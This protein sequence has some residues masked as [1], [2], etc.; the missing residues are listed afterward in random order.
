MQTSLNP[1]ARFAAFL[2]ALVALVALATQLVL[3]TEH[4]GGILPAL[5]ILVRYFTIL[6]NL[7]VAVTFSAMALSG[8]APGAGWLTGL[9]LWILIVGIVYHALL[10]RLFHP[11]GID[12]WTDQGLHTA[13]PLLAALWWLIFAPKH[14]LGLKHAVWWLGWP[15]AYV[16]YALIRSPLEGIYPYFFIDVSALGPARVALNSAGLTFAFF[17]GGLAMVGTAKALTR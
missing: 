16:A 2:V 8:R 13:D 4:N 5:W 12:W 6:T 14:G 9:T 10:A 7:L 11:V 1:T 3:S 15:L 17:V